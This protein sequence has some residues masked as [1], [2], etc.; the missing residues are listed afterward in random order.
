MNPDG[1]LGCG[2]FIWMLACALALGVAIGLTFGLWG[3]A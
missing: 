3:C 2:G 1:S